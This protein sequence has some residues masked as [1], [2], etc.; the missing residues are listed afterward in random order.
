[1]AGGTLA[2]NG[3]LKLFEKTVQHMLRSPNV[4]FRLEGRQIAL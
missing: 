3:T 1:V 4:E 2:G